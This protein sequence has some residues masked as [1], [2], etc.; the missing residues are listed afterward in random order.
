VKAGPFLI[1]VRA[2]V[3]QEKHE[4]EK[5]RQTIQPPGQVVHSEELKSIDSFRADPRYG[6]DSTRINLAYAIYAASHGVGETE[7]AAAI[8]SRDLSHKGGERRTI[9]WNAPFTSRST[10][11]G[12]T[13]RVGGR[14]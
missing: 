12:I 10:A 4:R 2:A 14:R 13:G 11:G 7:I 5:H 6:G 3:A 9:M 1:A 8:H